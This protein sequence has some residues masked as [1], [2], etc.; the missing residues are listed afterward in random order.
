MLDKIARQSNAVETES[1]CLVA[2]SS[3]WT[4]RADVHVLDYDGGLLDCCCI[5]LMAALR[6]FRRPEVTVRDG[7]L[8]VHGLNEKAPVP[9]N[10]TTQ[11]L[12]C[13]FNV[14]DDGKI[15]LLDPSM[16]EEQA[17]QGSVVVAL[18]P[19][20]ELCLFSKM[21]GVPVLALKLIDCSNIALAKVKQHAK[22]ISK[23]LEED[24]KVRASRHP[25]AISSAAND[26]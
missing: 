16:K 7:K 19:A 15:M 23:K 3:A 8:T 4:I 12:S 25:G 20:G 21:D 18:N 14:F 6:H 10:I 26:R 5:A 2:G 13:T 9:L 24:A 11:P 17:G 22:I 1:L